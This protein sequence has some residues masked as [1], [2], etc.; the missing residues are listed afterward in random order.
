MPVPN[1]LSVSS[2]R[3]MNDYSAQQ[4][5]PA[6]NWNPLAPHP[7]EK[8][9]AMARGMQGFAQGFV[10]P[11]RTAQI[12]DRRHELM[13][14]DQAAAK[15]A[16]GKTLAWFQHAR[17]MPEAQRRQFM[18]STAGEINPKIAQALQ[19]AGTANPYADGEIDQAIAAISA[20]LGQGPEKPEDVRFQG[21]NLGNGGVGVLD[22]RTGQL[23]IER[24]PQ[25]PDPKQA[26]P[27]NWQRYELADGVYAVNPQ[28]PAERMRI[29]DGVPRS[30]GIKIAPDGTVTIGGPS[31]DGS[32][33]TGPNPNEKSYYKDVGAYQAA[34]AQRDTLLHNLTEAK[35]LVGGWT[36]GIGG[37][38]MKNIPGSPAVNLEQRIATVQAL[39]G[40]DALQQMRQNSPT[41]G[42]LGAITERELAFLQAVQGSLA[43]IQSD[44]QLSK[45]M[46]EV[47]ASVKRLAEA[48]DQAF[49]MQ[50]QALEPGQTRDQPRVEGGVVT[51]YQ[52]MSTE[53]L[54][55]RAEEL[56]AGRGR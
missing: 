36:T 28:N 15:D 9:S 19:N 25:M 56:R 23:R 6:M 39:I 11:E 42:A 4:P 34:K 26:A 50:Y 16:A 45:V 12:Q 33:L 44:E 27:P 22:P 18:M 21:M 35:K 13:Q 5:G 51:P 31:A 47:E 46:D 40:F 32:Q 41:G 3:P 55:R 29:G 53:D 17:K 37:A 24:E 30:G 38:I 54:R 2:M 10:G 14:R 43:T 52:G 8:R 7:P 48:Q 1:A 20:Q 49:Q